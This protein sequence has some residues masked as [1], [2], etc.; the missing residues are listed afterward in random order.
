MRTP[1]ITSV[2]A[3]PDWRLALDWETGARSVVDVSDLVGEY[4]VFAP[5][6]EAPALFAA[7]TVGEDG[8]CVH[9]SDLMELSAPNLWRRSQALAAE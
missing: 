4:Q 9:W 1:R 8:F 7:V 2:K 5:L 6:R 3:L